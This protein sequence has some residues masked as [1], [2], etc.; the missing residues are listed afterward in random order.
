MAVTSSAI[1][2]RVQTGSRSTDPATLPRQLYLWMKL[3]FASEAD[4]PISKIAI[5]VSTSSSAPLS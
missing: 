5:L 1:T 2:P 4:T 3:L